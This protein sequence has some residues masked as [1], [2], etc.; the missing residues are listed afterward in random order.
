MTF[1]Q[2]GVYI[3]FPVLFC[4]GSLNEVAIVYDSTLTDVVVNNDSINDSTV[5]SG[6]RTLS[7]ANITSGVDGTITFPSSSELTSLFG[8]NWS[9]GYC[10]QMLVHRLSI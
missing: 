9:T 8:A 4:L 7:F 2:E 1:P 5:V 10:P 3:L 6:F